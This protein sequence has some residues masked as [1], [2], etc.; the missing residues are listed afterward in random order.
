MDVP[1]AFHYFV[2]LFEV[3]DEVCEGDVCEVEFDEGVVDV[4]QFAVVLYGEVALFDDF[5]L[6]DV[7]F[8]DF[9]PVEFR[10]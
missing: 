8:L 1:L 10:C 7:G 4:G 9:A 5:V 2:V 3:D 6:E